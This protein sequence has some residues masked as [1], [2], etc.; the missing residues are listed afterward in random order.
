MRILLV[1]TTA[2]VLSLG[3]TAWASDH[4]GTV[5][6]VDPGQG[7]IV[8]D[9]VGPWQMKGGKTVSTQRMFAVDPSTQFLV[10]K[11]K[12]EPGAS[13]WPGDFT[14]TTLGAWAVKAGDFVTVRV[15][16]KAKRLVATRITVTATAE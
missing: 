6:A 15:E 2:I 5:V 13:G 7:T 10:L 11:R 9:E 8:I 12:T 3:T 16:E 4:S 14:E 1:G